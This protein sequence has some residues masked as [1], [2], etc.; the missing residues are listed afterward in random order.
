[1]EQH[2]LQSRHDTEPHTGRANDQSPSTAGQRLPGSKAAL[3]GMPGMA[4]MQAILDHVHFGL[5]VVG[6]DNQL[7]FANQAAQR[8]CC[9]GPL[10]RSDGGS[11]VAAQPAD[12][13][14]LRKS[15]AAAR[16]GRWTL[17]QLRSGADTM[18]LALIPMAQLELGADA[19]VLVVF[20][21]RGP[22]KALAIQFYARSCGLTAAEERV[23]RSLSEGL[24]PRAVA[25]QHGVELSTVR[26]QLRSIRNKS[27]VCSVTELMRTLGCLPPIMPAGLRVV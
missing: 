3:A 23:L 20:G 18:M 17:V 19:P 11:L 15:M 14:G 26:S 12:A 1:M 9:Q 7:L 22:C 16:S 27:G 21:V 5:A 13:N 24:S 8:E 2:A 6:P 10:L 25:R 4:L